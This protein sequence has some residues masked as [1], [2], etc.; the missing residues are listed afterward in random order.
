MSDSEKLRLALSRHFVDSGEKERLMGILRTRL[1]EAGWNDTLYA[2]CRDTVRQRK[3]ENVT[4]DEL[5]KEASDYG[6]STVNE[7]IKKELLVQIKKYLDS[8]FD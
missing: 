6:R 2:H 1:A 4:L 8:A 3:L 7:N 5:A